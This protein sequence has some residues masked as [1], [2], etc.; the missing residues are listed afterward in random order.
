[1]TTYIP[2]YDTESPRCLA[3]LPRIVEIHEKHAMPATF[4]VVARL[5]DS[6]G[7]ELVRRLGRNPL[8]EIASHSYTHL[9][10]RDV[11]LCGKAGPPERFE[12]EIVGSKRRIEDAF[13]RP[14]A[15][16]RAPVSFYN[17]FRGAPRL[18]SLL[19]QAG[20]AYSSSFGWGPHDTLPVLPGESFTYAEDGHP[21]L[22]EIPACGWHENLLKG[23]NRWEPR[24]LQLYPHP[25]PEA[26]VTGFVQTPEEEFAVHKLFLDRAARENLGHVSLIWHPWSLNAFDPEMRMPDLV[27]GYVRGLGLACDTFEGYLKKMKEGAHWS[28]IRKDSGNF[29][30]GSTER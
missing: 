1:M 6:D 25:M 24:P 4:F 22:W 28:G 11:R 13:G 12:H 7:G 29:H 3:A 23:N 27:F 19:A 16:F 20:Y 21:D 15:G 2:A 8:F 9:L 5:L 26:A 30:S 18:L 10:L 14:V 17:A